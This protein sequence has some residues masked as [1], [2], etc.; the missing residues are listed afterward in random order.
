MGWWNSQLNGK[1]KFMFQTTNQ[2]E[3]ASKF[4]EHFI[5]TSQNIPVW[6]PWWP[7]WPCPH[8]HVPIPKLSWLSWHETTWTATS[9]CRCLRDV[10]E[11]N[12]VQVIY[13]LVSCV[14]IQHDTTMVTYRDIWW[15]RTVA[16]LQATFILKKKLD[17]SIGPTEAPW[18]DQKRSDPSMPYS[19]GIHTAAQKH[20]AKSSGCSRL[21]N[22]QASLSHQLSKASST[23]PAMAVLDANCLGLFSCR[24]RSNEIQIVWSVR[25]KDLWSLD[26]DCR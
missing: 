13:H 23:E 9:C 11:E 6:W 14:A 15:P 25:Y 22:K 26:H 2:H 4:I 3:L 19:H 12:G 16:R 17:I 1:I 7:W 21:R 18:N 5:K 8:G 20:P 24:L 10:F